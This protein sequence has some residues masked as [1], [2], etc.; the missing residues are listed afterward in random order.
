LQV[1]S[2]TVEKPKIS[3]F[4][5]KY[6][7]K[8]R[9]EAIMNDEKYEAAKTRVKELKDFYRNLLTYAGVNILLIIINLVTSPESLW[10]YWV[11]IFWGIGIVLH[12]SKIFILK[13]KFLGKE[14][15]E[16]KIKEMMEKE[17]NSK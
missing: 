8:N 2:E 7:E 10:F 16:K 12:A 1:F 6:N 17:S 5:A 4:G 14:W 9:E 15:E 11:T 3:N 13:G